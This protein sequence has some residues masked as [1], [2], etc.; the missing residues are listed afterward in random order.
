M[1]EKSFECEKMWEKVD[2][3][4]EGSESA[5]TCWGWCGGGRE[6]PAWAW[7]SGIVTNK[8]SLIVRRCL[9]W[10][11][12]RVWWVE[13]HRASRQ[14]KMGR[15]FIGAGHWRQKVHSY[16]SHGF[17]CILK[18]IFRIPRSPV[19]AQAG[20]NVVNQ[21]T[22]GLSVVPVGGE[23]VH[24]QI[25]DALL[26]PI[27]QSLPGC[28][29]VIG[30]S[31]V[32]IPHWHGDRVVQDQ[33]PD[34]AQNQLQLAVND[35]CGVDVDDFDALALEEFHRN[36]DVLQL[37][38]AE[39]RADVVLAHLL[40]WQHFDEG[41]K[42]QAIRQVSFQAVDGLVDDL[43]VLVRP[44]RE[45]VCLDALPLSICAGMQGS[46]DIAE[47]FIKQ[48]NT[49]LQLNHVQLQSFLLLLVVLGNPISLTKIFSSLDRNFKTE[50]SL[51]T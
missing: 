50:Q 11:F 24:R 44:S 49:H 29:L 4:S 47:I 46:R 7:H 37:L 8:S 20:C 33:Q 6:L 19:R 30:C 21:S 26:D 28:L 45:C 41:D 25:W 27:E 43:Q 2:I 51:V 9:G 15:K 1:R 13:G 14:P 34:E 10:S 17:G 22:D 42:R 32:G 16:K 18:G 40:L 5:L 31:G 36:R 38:G 3:V 35:V 48:W 12:H 23:V 39:G